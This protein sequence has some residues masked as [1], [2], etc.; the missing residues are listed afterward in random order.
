MIIY[1]E[2]KN[3]TKTK[4]RH[5]NKFFDFIIFKNCIGS[6]YMVN[7]LNLHPLF[8]QKYAGDHIEMDSKQVIEQINK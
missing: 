8:T 7:K 5:Q 6:E 1:P 2:T 3:N 4:I